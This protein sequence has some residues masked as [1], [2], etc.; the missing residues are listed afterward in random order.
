MTS[1]GGTKTNAQGQLRS[2]VS[3]V[4][5]R[6]AHNPVFQAE[7]PLSIWLC[8]TPIGTPIGDMNHYLIRLSFCKSIPFSAINMA[9]TWLIFFLIILIL[10]RLPS[11]NANS[12]I[13]VVPL[14]LILLSPL[15]KAPSF[16]LSVKRILSTKVILSRDTLAW[17]ASVFLII[18]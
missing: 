14:K 16:I 6:T 17:W 7:L 8:Q 1:W 13:N 2:T 11:W 3:Q 18:K 5:T 9:I 15:L 4:E 10:M 12:W